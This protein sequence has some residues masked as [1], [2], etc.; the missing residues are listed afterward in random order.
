MPEDNINNFIIKNDDNINMITAYW[1]STQFGGK[2][3]WKALKHNGVLF[4]PE[5]KKHDTSVIYKGD[6]IKLD[7]IAEEYATMYAKYIDSEY[8]RNS[9]FRKNFWKDW[10]KVL[11]TDHIIQS[12]EDCNFSLINEYLIKEKEAKKTLSPE[13]KKTKDDYEKYA[14]IRFKDR[15]V[16]QY[17]I[18]YFDPPN[19]LYS[20]QESYN[21]SFVNIFRHCLDVYKKSIPDVDWDGWV[22]SFEMNDGTVLERLDAD[23]NELENLKK[24]EGDWYNV[25]RQFH[26]KTVPDKAIVWPFSSNQALG[27]NGWGPRIEI[28]IPKV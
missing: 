25:W 8:I 3:K 1:L 6:H 12:L 16:Q 23:R 15:A 10:K 9:V 11:G 5:Y 27:D 26:T 13:E 17:T 20:T 18:S 19:P 22:V 21:D 7:P 2:T 24:I 4:P 14:G 28:T